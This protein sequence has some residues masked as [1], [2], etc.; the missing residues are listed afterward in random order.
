MESEYEFDEKI[1]FPVKVE[2][3]DIPKKLEPL[4]PTTPLS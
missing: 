1:V 4:N 2:A 3:V